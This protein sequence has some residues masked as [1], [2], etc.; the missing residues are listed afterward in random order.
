MLIGLGIVTRFGLSRRDISDRFEQA[1][2]VEPIDPFEGGE[3][4][5][6]RT[7]PRTTP[8]VNAG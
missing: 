3:L 1:T 2:I 8:V 7:A 4:D 5:R 6:F